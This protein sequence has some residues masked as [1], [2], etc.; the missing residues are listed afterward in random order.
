[1]P[2]W[3]PFCG[4]A[5]IV[6]FIRAPKGIVASD[7]NAWLALMWQQVQAGWIPPDCVTEETYY[8]YRANKPM[9]PETA[10]IGFGC[11]FGGDWFKGYARHKKGTT[12]PYC[13]P[14]EAWD[15]IKRKLANFQTDPPIQFRRMD[16]LQEASPWDEPAV[17]YCDPPYAQT[18]QYLAAKGFNSRYFWER[19]RY[20]A[21][22][23]NT[24]FVSEYNGPELTGA[25]VEIEVVWQH[26]KR[27]GLRTAAGGNELRLEKLFLVKEN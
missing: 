15:S 23:G 26:E 17:V 21:R 2:Y 10:F 12:D 20:L 16:F 3:E 8:W 6:Q 25:E 4:G 14:R 22:Q 27:M 5:N 7:F 13:F 18:T 19:C 24:V 1:M 11:A 9:T